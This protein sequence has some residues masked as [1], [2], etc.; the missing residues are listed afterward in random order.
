MQKVNM[1]VQQVNTK[2]LKKKLPSFTSTRY[3][4]DDLEYDKKHS[5]KQKP[6]T[7]HYPKVSPRHAPIN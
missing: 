7:Q 3:K 6:V 2:M 1:N 5:R 4:Y